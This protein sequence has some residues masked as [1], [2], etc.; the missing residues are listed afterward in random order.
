MVELKKNVAPF[1]RL[2]RIHWDVAPEGKGV[3]G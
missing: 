1:L 3:D 2:T